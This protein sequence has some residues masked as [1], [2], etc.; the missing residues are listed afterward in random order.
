MKK[1]LLLSIVFFCLSSCGSF[2]YTTYDVSLAKVETP[3]NVKEKY[4]TT[5]VVVLN[6]S[7]K[8]N[9]KYE[10]DLFNIIWYPTRKQLNFSITNISDYSIKILWDESV[11]IDQEGKTGRV[12]HDG[13]KYIDRNNSM[14]ASIIPKGTSLDDIIVPTSNVYYSSG[15]GWETSA[16]VHVNQD[17]LKS[18]PSAYEGVTIKIL[19]PLEIEGIKNE[20]TFEFDVYNIQVK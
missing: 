8:T 18:N 14:P 7:G 5:D 4:G 11:F 20:Y 10:N 2:K 17:L 6:E 9:Y 19:L 13:V 12:M 1:I 16:L 15:I 3:Q